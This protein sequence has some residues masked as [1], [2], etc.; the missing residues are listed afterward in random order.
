M[1]LILLLIVGSALAYISQDNL[2]PVSV[3]VGQ[4]VFEGIP[5]FYVIMVSLITGLL[6]SYVI[7]LTH[8]ISGS[9]VLR[10]KNKKI[11]KGEDEVLELTKRVH[12]LE[13]EKERLKN[14][15]TPDLEDPHAL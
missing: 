10:G 7:N 13:L 14:D 11:E 12:Q 9:W 15:S 8:A 5:L 4:Y 3:H 1:V 6:L 2:M